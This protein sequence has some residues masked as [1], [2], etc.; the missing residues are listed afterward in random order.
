[1]KLFVDSNYGIAFHVAP[2]TGAWIE[3]QYQYTRGDAGKVAP[4]TGAW[5]ETVV[6]I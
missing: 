3:T 5:I 6:V 2:F 4:F 1:M